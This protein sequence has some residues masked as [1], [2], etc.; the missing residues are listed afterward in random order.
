MTLLRA[1]DL[2]DNENLD[3]EE[4]QIAEQILFDLAEEYRLNLAKMALEINRRIYDLS[5]LDTRLI[6][7]AIGYDDINFILKEYVEPNID[8]KE[9][10]VT[11]M[12]NLEVLK[13][14]QKEFG[15]NSSL[16]EFELTSY[17]GKWQRT[18]KKIRD[19]IAEALFPENKK[20]LKTEILAMMDK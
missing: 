10:I 13:R 6:T 1:M 17:F 15:E 2:L 7:K 3:N 19:K 11:Y 14:F 5:I 4:V 9:R 16:V 8:L 18:Y 20:L 12:N